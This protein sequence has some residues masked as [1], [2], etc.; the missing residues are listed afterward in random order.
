MLYKTIKMVL[1]SLMFLGSIDSH[2]SDIFKNKSLFKVSQPLSVEQAFDLSIEKNDNGV[3]ILFDIKENHYLYESKIKIKINNIEYNDYSI[4]GSIEKY[5][6]YYGLTNVIY[7][8]LFI[9]IENIENIEKIQVDYQ[10]CSE[11]FGICYQ[12]VSVVK[13]YESKKILLPIDDNNNETS[14][15]EV[16]NV[17]MLDYFSV[18]NLIGILNESSIYINILIFFIAGILIS[19]TPCILPMI[20]IISSIILSQKKQSN[21]VAFKISLS[22]VL[23][24]STAY[25]CVGVIAAITGKN[26]Q[27]YLQSDIFIVI[28][29]ILLMLLAISM[30]DVINLQTPS[31]FNNYVSGKINNLNSDNK[32]SI[33]IIG[34]LSTLIVSPCVA[35][36][37]AAAAIYISKTGD[38]LLGSMSLFSFGMG[39]GVILIIISTSLNKFKVKSGSFMVEIK[40]LMGLLLL[41]ASIYILER[42]V[43][44]YISYLFYYISMSLYLVGLY[45]RVKTTKTLILLILGFGLIFNATWNVDQ[46]KEKNKIV[47]AELKSV[48][49]YADAITLDKNIFIKVTADWCV[50][51]KKMDKMTLNTDEFK[52]IS[53]DY[54]KYKIDLTETSEKKNILLKKLGVIAPPA[55][56]YI[57]DGV[58]KHKE[59]G[60]I[61]IEKLKEILK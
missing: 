32:L 59:F 47:Y 25:A 33:F 52:N 14:D 56:I 58:I 23:G 11:S 36:P 37:L 16:N 12:P 3:K 61:S 34:F 39:I 31:K 13:K 40:Y 26:L 4:L 28:S 45:S 38:V 35:A 43:S 60:F 15:I 57:T 20:P 55:I 5:D 42:V 44:S 24:S 27:V 19:L 17:K 1:I 2:A 18:N 49:D 48:S 41:I 7:N 54:T 22:Y 21:K 6:E 51:C 10:G 9:N 30:F 46:S 53:L 29:S 50:Y 8:N